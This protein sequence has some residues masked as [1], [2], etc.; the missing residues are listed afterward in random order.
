MKQ[1]ISKRSRSVAGLIMAVGPLVQPTAAE[2]LPGRAMPANTE[3]GTVC[4]V[5][6]ANGAQWF[7]QSCR[8]EWTI[9]YDTAG[10][11]IRFVYSDNGVLP[12]GKPAPTKAMKWPIGGLTPFGDRICS[13]VEVTAASG[14]YSSTC[15][16][17]HP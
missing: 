10:N 17:T 12:P 4:L 11:L 9:Q 7:D 3:K 13:G 1:Y 14:Q 6:D 8:Y 5:R 15:F 16:Y 2:A